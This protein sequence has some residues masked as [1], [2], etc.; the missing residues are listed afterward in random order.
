[1]D[2]HTG[3]RATGDLL[4]Q[5]WQSRASGARYPLAGEESKADW[6]IPRQLRAQG[7][8]FPARRTFLGSQ[9]L[10]RRQTPPDFA[11]G[12]ITDLGRLCFRTVT[13]SGEGSFEGC[14]R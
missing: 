13:G 12:K 8:L 14:L 4:V 9:I 11:G 10:P 7:N 5:A 6:R 3:P 2:L 1:M